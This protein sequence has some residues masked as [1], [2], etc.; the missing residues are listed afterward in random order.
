MVCLKCE[1]ELSEDMFWKDSQS[2]CKECRKAATDE[3]RAANKD[4]LREKKREYDRKTA[5]ERNARRREKRKQLTPEQVEAE[6]QRQRDSVTRTRERRVAEYLA[7][8]G[9]PPMCECGCGEHVKF[10]HWG[11]PNRFVIGHK[12]DVEK[13]LD[14]QYED[15]YIP[16]ERVREALNKIRQ[17]RGWTVKELAEQAG[18]S[19]PHMRSVL[20]SKKQFKK[21]GFDAKWIENM[22]RR[23]Q[24]MPAPPT[25]YMLKTF[26]EVE[27]RYR[28][29][30]RSLS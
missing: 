13:M 18:L 14:K 15:H 20:Y 3:W 4:R 11:K 16:V 2:S 5:K 21:Y 8:H 22:F 30:E 24:G 19:L 23:I 6:K 29:T 26:T 7:E 28:E 17:E 9:E 25:S 12:I 10:S 27:R 1:R